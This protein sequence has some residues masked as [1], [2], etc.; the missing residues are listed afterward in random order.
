MAAACFFAR[1]QHQP[2]AQMQPV[3]FVHFA[4]GPLRPVFEADGRQFVVSD[5]GERVYGV[6]YIPPED[7]AVPI[8]VEAAGCATG[9]C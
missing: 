4:H 5:D 8:I 1:Q 9:E 3:A 6:W 7:S 2:G